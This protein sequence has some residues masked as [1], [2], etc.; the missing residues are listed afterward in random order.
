[1]TAAE[2]ARKTGYHQD[3]VRDRARRLGIKRVPSRGAPKP[4][5]VTVRSEPDIPV[6]DAGS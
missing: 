2:I 5:P 4:S 3:G 6:Y 1:M